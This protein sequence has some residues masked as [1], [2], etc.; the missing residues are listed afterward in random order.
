MP[1]LTPHVQGI[2]VAVR[3]KFLAHE[4]SSQRSKSTAAIRSA[5]AR[6][7]GLGLLEKADFGPKNPGWYGL[8][9]ATVTSLNDEVRRRFVVIAPMCAAFA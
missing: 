4:D 6:L 2:Y 1:Q 9:R 3:R 8:D 5:V 7:V